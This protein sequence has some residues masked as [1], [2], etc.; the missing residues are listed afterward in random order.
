MKCRNAR[1]LVSEFIDGLKSD[2]IR[3]ELEKHLSG[4]E[5]CD[6]Y[7]S[8]LTRC[9]DLLHRAPRETTSD[10]FA[11]KVRLKLNQERNSVRERSASYGTLIRSW[12]LRFATTAASAAAVVLVGGLFLLKS[13]VEP[14]TPDR[15]QSPRVA[16]ETSP[17]LTPR[18]FSSQPEFNITRDTTPP[19]RSVGQPSDLQRGVSTG[20]PVALAHRP[21]V[22]SW[23]VGNGSPNRS[24]SGRIIG[25]DLIDRT[26]PM[27][28]ASMDSL[29]N[30]QL[31]GLNADEQVQYLSRYIISLQRHLLRAQVERHRSH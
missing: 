16:E 8:Q 28:V 29:V 6:K 14:A 3:L 4:C 15:Y 23:L 21:S 25:V 20:P 10:N 2:T 9:M 17:T 11:W 1:K 7:A 30:V 31:N 24:S 22:S 26:Q 18:T 19:A 13:A 5:E 27:S 12:N